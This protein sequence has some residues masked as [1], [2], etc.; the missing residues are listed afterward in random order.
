MERYKNLCDFTTASSNGK[1]RSYL[2]LRKN[3]ISKQ[4]RLSSNSTVLE[5][6]DIPITEN[7]LRDLFRDDLSKPFSAAA[8]RFPTVGNEATLDQDRSAFRF[9]QDLETFRFEA[10][11]SGHETPAQF[12]LD[13]TGQFP[14]RSAARPV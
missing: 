14:S 4:L 1:V 5:T 9:L 3:G 10:A 12:T 8:L 2:K 7:A 6:L 11:I 13:I